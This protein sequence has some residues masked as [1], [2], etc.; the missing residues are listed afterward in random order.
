[1]GDRRKIFGLGIFVILVSTLGV[2]HAFAQENFLV[3]ENSDMGIRIDYPSD[4][5]VSDSL[6]GTVDFYAPQDGPDDDFAEL[7]SVVI[8]YLT[9]P[10]TLEEYVDVVVEELEFVGFSV[11]DSKSIT[12]ADNPAN[13][14]TILMEIEGLE[15]DLRQIA[16]IKDETVYLVYMTT[17]PQ[18]TSKYM[19][20]FEKMID[21]FEILSAS[22][23]TGQDVRDLI[24]DA[25]Q[26]YLQGNLQDALSKIETILLIQ[27]NHYDALILKGSILVELGKNVEAERV[28]DKILDLSVYDPF[29][30]LIKALALIGQEKY[31]ESIEYIDEYL[32]VIPQD[33]LGLSLKGIALAELGQQ[34]EAIS[35]ID[36]ALELHPDFGFSL[37]A[38]GYYYYVYKDYDKAILFYDKALEVEP[39][40]L[41]YLNDKGVALMDQGKM[42]EAEAVFDQ[43]LRETPDDSYALNNKGV[44]L[45]DRGDNAKAIEYFDRASEIE[46]DN[47]LFLQN[48]IAALSSSG[49][50]DLAQIAYN[51]I[52]Q[53]NPDYDIPLESITS[54]ST[55]LDTSESQIDPPS[56]ELETGPAESTQIPDWVRGNAEWWA[57]GLIG[58][59]DFVSGIQYLIKEGIM[60][61]PETTQGTTAGGAEE[62][63][64]WIKNNA[65]WWAQGLITDDDFV[66]GIQYLIENGI[67]GI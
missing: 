4:W 27:E 7:M 40:E 23:K 33:S 15:I 14:I 25:N 51:Q 47:L 49:I 11:T 39:G 16:T 61:I 13:Q 21:S 56:M 36:E 26:L 20:T 53:L 52:L 17:S 18:T 66:K 5:T 9:E 38:K 63:P 65:D 46:P 2:N 43:I 12:L 67:M 37:Y 29:A 24:D 45:L 22:E 31:E 57:Q 8:E 41:G 19:P 64:S 6:F 44:V 42:K 60:Q 58:D 10:V 54:A 59:S 3:Y 1:M 30:S 50:T 28:A 32:I 48:K 62:I 55:S 35:I 34:D